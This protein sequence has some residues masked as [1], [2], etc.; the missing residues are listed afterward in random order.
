V[1][2]HQAR[3]GP[4]KLIFVGKFALR[5]KPEVGT[6]ILFLVIGLRDVFTS[7]VTTIAIILAMLYY[8]CIGDTPH[9]MVFYRG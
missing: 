5:Q 1:L 7:I 6:F 3:F 2:S 9:S 8:L 4:R